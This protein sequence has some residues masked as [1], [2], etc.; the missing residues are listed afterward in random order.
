MTA[1][2]ALVP[3]AALRDDWDRLVDASDDGWLWHRSAYVEALCTWPGRS[4]ASFAV[5][6][7]SELVAV[8]PL[9]VVER[10]FGPV[11]Q[12]VLDSAAGPA[13][14][15]GLAT[16]EKRATLDFC[17]DA[18]RRLAGQHRAMEIR[19]TMSPLAPAARAQIEPMHH[20]L[21][22]LGMRPVP[23][24]AWLVD[25]REGP[26]DVRRRIQRK[27]RN[28]LAVA[29]RSGVSVRLA[30]RPGDLDA[31]Y[32]LHVTTYRRTGARPHPQT[33]FEHIWRDFVAHGHAIALLAEYEAKVVAG[34]TF[35]LFKNGAAYWTGASD[36][37]G[38]LVHANKLLQWEGMLHTMMRGAH[39]FESGEALPW[40][41]TGK[42]AGLSD[43]KRKFGGTLVP[44]NRAVLDTAGPGQA[45]LRTARGLWSTRPEDGL[46]S[47]RGRRER[48]S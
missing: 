13:I 14:A 8:F 34:A 5:L 45:L 46:I 33:Y 24:Y 39:W 6:R 9:H 16:A 23:S 36:E 4:D 31:Y 28:A 19:A 47:L 25:L 21:L 1:V 35:A 27:T 40:S 11:R 17:R 2:F 43:F 22:A 37:S 10:G 7:D 48:A 15:P 42:R 41:F 12:C 44:I 18:L 3:R 38:R 29:T 30:D 20:T 26:D 32:E